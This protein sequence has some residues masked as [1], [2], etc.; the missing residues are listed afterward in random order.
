VSRSEPSSRP[1]IDLGALVESL[2]EGD[3]AAVIAAFR[4]RTEAERRAVAPHLLGL[5]RAGWQYT[6]EDDGTMRRVPHRFLDT[7]VA[8][9]FG[10][11]TLTEIKRLDV[12]HKF[13]KMCNDTTYE[14]LVDRRP[15][16]VTSWASW[17]CERQAR[18]SGRAFGLFGLVRPLIR[19]GVCDPLDTDAYILAMVF[20]KDREYNFKVRWFGDPMCNPPR[21]EANRRAL[22]EHAAGCRTFTQK[23]LDDPAL[24]DDELWRIFDVGWR[25]SRVVSEKW[26]RHLITAFVTLAA[27][28]RI[29]RD[30]V[31][32]STLD[33]LTRDT[34]TPMPASFF[35]ALWRAFE[36]SLAERSAH[37]A[38]F[39]HL[40]NQPLSSVV[41]FALDQLEELEQ[42]GALHARGFVAEVEGVLLTMPVDTVLRALKALERIARDES[43]VA[44]EALVVV[45]AALL[46]ANPK[47]HDAAASV[48]ARCARTIDATVAAAI[49]AK[50]EGVS[51]ALVAR[52]RGLS[53]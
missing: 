16:W 25:P 50:L 32:S 34:T 36:P 39:L 5:R 7:A 11:C 2:Q 35:I 26:N 37:Q 21:D 22:A 14:V 41:S 47:V 8:A 27:T 53:D 17:A 10:C 12:E 49:E 6:I 1:P 52:L 31:L 20:W 51:P 42:D 4:G 18:K 48:L 13:G 43:D 29:E 38:G 33:T 15:P 24:I 30:R 28:G 19:A 3:D 23:L 45:T 46:H 40:L 44:A 9:L